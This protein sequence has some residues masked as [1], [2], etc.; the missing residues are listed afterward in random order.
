MQEEEKNVAV[1][2]TRKRGFKKSRKR[3]VLIDADEHFKKN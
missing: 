2:K 3:V 1:I